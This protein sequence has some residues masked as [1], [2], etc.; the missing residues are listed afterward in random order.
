M[1][2]NGTETWTPASVSFSSMNIPQNLWGVS[3]V[4]LNE[5][6]PPGA[7]TTFSFTITAPE[8]PN[9][10]LQW[11]TMQHTDIPVDQTHMGNGTFYCDPVIVTPSCSSKNECEGADH[12]YC[13]QFVSEDVPNCMAPGS[14]AQVSVTMKNTGAST[15]D[16]HVCLRP[17]DNSLWSLWNVKSVDLP[18]QTPPGSTAT[19]KFTITAPS[20]PGNYT[21][22]WS[23][24]DLGTN[25]PFGTT[26]PVRSIQ[27]TPGCTGAGNQDQLIFIPRMGAIMLDD[28][29]KFKS[30]LQNAPPAT[31]PP[32]ANAN[33]G[34]SSFTGGV[35][36]GTFD[37][38]FK[39]DASHPP[40]TLHIASI[41]TGDVNGDGRADMILLCKGDAPN[42]PN[43]LFVCLRNSDGSYGYPQP[44]TGK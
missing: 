40:L 13:S 35:R 34:Q 42:K 43:T 39:G 38:K 25:S 32:G 1:R 11:W 5:E 16:S 4:K 28:P 33:S 6:V 14:N 15:W 19:F 31:P 29:Q 23:M 30:M 18:Q 21:H 44:K 3:S 27:V 8:T 36:P 20:T 24:F 10:Y 2:N 22:S 41:A 12:H 9:N 17:L 7:K 26:P 37:M